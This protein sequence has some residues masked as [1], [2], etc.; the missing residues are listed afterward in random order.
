MPGEEHPHDPEDGTPPDARPAATTPTTRRAAADDGAP[1]RDGGKGLRRKVIAACRDYRSGELRGDRRRH[2]EEAAKGSA[3]LEEFCGR[4]LGGRD[5]G[6][7]G[8]GGQG[9]GDGQGGGKNGDGG[10]GDPRRRRRGERR[11]GRRRHG[12]W[13]GRR[14]Y[15]RRPRPAPGPA[16]TGPHRLLQR[17]APSAVTR[18]G[19]QV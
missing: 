14:R 7:G 9:N 3:R 4:V 18:P 1:R 5:G 19:R 16:R 13:L 11:L 6:R 2:L 8:G 17:P 10:D 12:R 15:R